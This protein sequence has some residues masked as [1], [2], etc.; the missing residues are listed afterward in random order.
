V[1]GNLGISEMFEIEYSTVWFTH[2]LVYL[3]VFNTDSSALGSTRFLSLS[4]VLV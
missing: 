1:E 4:S 2:F 3:V